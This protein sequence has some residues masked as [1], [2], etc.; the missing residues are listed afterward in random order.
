MNWLKKCVILAHRYLGIALSL[1][2][3]MWF[4]SGIVMMYAGG[5]PRLTTERRLDRLPALDLSRVRLTPSDAA[6]RAGT[7]G[8]PGRVVLLS[9]MDRPAYRFAGGRTTTV[10]ADSGELMMDVSL[11]QATTIASRFM[12]LPEDKIHY[13]RTLTKEDQWTLGQGRQLPLY[14]FSADDDSGTEL[15]VAPRT[16][17]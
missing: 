14:K 5:M 16:G 2:I 8:T 15:Y 4:A 3:V 7:D 1:L 10:F 9:V 12:N 17:T 6:E 13:V 11:A